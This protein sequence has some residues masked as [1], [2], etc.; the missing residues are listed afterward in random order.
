MEK[1]V[2]YLRPEWWSDRYVL[3][4]Y[5]VTM[6]EKKNDNFYRIRKYENQKSS[7]GFRIYFFS[8]I[9]SWKIMSL[10]RDIK[11]LTKTINQP[12]LNK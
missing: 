11:S 8:S 10:V 3:S 6:E 1:G 5:D 2:I 9:L 12:Y 7:Y 4:L